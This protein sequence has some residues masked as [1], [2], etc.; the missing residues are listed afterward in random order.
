MKQ[1]ND[2]KSIHIDL[3]KGIFE[4]NGEDISKSM[5]LEDEETGKSLVISL[6]KGKWIIER[7]LLFISTN[8]EELMGKIKKRLNE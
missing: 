8:D 7:N 4:L 5:I 2:F 6:Y 1:I 3:E